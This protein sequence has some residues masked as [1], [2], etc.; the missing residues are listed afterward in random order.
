[1]KHNARH[2]AQGAHGAQNISG[3]GEP[4]RKRSVGRSIVMILAKIMLTVGVVCALYVL[5]M[6]WW[7]GV[8]SEHAQLE[9]RANSSWAQPASDGKN[10]KIAQPQSGEPPVQ[11]TSANVGELIARVYIPRFGDTWERNLVQGT[12]LTELNMHGLGHYVDSQWPGQVG[13]FAFAGHRNGYGQPLGDVDKLKAGDAV[14]IRT[15]D[16]WYVYNYTNYIIVTPDQGE[17]I[18]ANPENP[19]AP[20]TKRM[21]TMTTCEPKY[22]APTHR[23]VSFGEFKYWAKVSDG[24]PKELATNGS[25]GNVQ[26]INNEST[27]FFA[28]LDSLKPVIYGLLAAYVI[29][30]IAAAFAWRWPLLRAIRNGERSKPDVDIYGALVRHQPGPGVIRW[31]LTLLLFL[32]ASAAVVEWACPWAA[33]HIEILREM[34]NYTAITPA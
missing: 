33:S 8:Q 32:A 4:P 6:Q 11:P 19:S 29:I 28:Q 27:P 13:N 17:V 3:A 23:W 12:D 34:S 22:T 14:V 24:I 10:A 31:L 30:F 7:T 2:D 20:A 9:E 15:K 18:S 25:N 1:M 26:F 21:L 5:W 16:Y